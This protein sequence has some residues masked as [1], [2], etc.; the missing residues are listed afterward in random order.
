MNV[1]TSEVGGGA[2]KTSTDPHHVRVDI[3][4]SEIGDLPVHASRT[5]NH[6]VADA[7]GM[8]TLGT[9]LVHEFGHGSY[10]VCVWGLLCR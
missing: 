3:N 5:G 10:A 9:A 1:T 2:R 6:D 4:P 8:M 7:L